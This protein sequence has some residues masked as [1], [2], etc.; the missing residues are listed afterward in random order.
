MSFL[1]MN[2]RSRLYGLDLAR[3]L[4]MAGIV[5][6]N[7]RLALH[8]AATG[9]VWLERC[10][11]LLEGKT[12]ATFVVLAGL[13]LVLTTAARAPVPAQR[14]VLRRALVLLAFGLLNLLIFPADILHYYAVYLMLALPL[15]HA[16]PRT[17]GVAIMLVAA[18]SFAA[19]QRFDYQTGWDWITLD[20][21]DL[22]TWRG[23]IR[24]LLF[25]GFH[26]VLPWVALFFY[27]MLLAH[28]PLRRRRFQWLLMC[29]GALAMGLA[30]V[31]ARRSAH[32][33]WGWLLDTG[34]MPAGPAYLC[35]A[36]GFAS[37][38]IGACLRLA[39]RWR[40]PMLQP[41]L[42]TG[43]MTLSVYLGH[44]VLG[45]GALGA[46]GALDGSWSLAAAV[47]AATLYI[48]LATVAASRWH[49][50]GFYGPLE[51]L[52]RRLSLPR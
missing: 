23:A 28:L 5:L 14:F 34:P 44:T 6:V 37:C 8:P 27:G 42:A 32:S 51:L 35:M 17:L 30:L 21:A 38:I 20:Y 33:A 40:W 41:M 19:L 25:N 1:Q 45:M 26:P 2:A 18:G 7:F 22:W 49:R 11:D 46:L 39:G 50:S 12:T 4:T 16:G 31:I 13:S 48:A 52:V 10:F 36:A 47:G 3:Y 29:G 9:P 24:N 43:R 15:L